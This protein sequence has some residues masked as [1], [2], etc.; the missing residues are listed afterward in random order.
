MDCRIWF[1][2]LDDRRAS[3][4]IIHCVSSLSTTLLS[5]LSVTDAALQHHVLRLF[6]VAWRST[7][8][9]DSHVLQAILASLDD[10]IDLIVDLFYND[11]ISVLTLALMLVLRLELG[12]V[13]TNFSNRLND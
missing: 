11:A 8:S 13:L 2:F 1:F 12:L 7:V 6:F 5:L 9:L 4:K 3:S 10:G